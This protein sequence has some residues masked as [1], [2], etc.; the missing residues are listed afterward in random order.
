MKNQLK[1]RKKHLK[2]KK[3]KRNPGPITE[4]IKKRR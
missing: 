4:K 2:S 1:R 3:Q